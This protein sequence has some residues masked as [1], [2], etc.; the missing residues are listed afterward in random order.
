VIAGRKETLPSMTTLPYWSSSSTQVN[1]ERVRSNRWD[2]IA[3]PPVS[4]AL[5]RPT[6]NLR[7]P[8]SAVRSTR[9][10]RCVFVSAT[11]NQFTITMATSGMLGETSVSADPPAVPPRVSLDRA[12]R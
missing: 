5:I 2:R 7:Q 6:S 9:S 8:M 11:P 4:S 12:P 3:A 10:G 1:R